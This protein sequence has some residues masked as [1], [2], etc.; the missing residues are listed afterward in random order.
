MGAFAVRGTV[1]H[2]GPPPLAQ[3]VCGV[4]PGWACRAIRR[5]QRLVSEPHGTLGLL[6]VAFSLFVLGVEVV[7]SPNL[8]RPRVLCDRVLR[9]LPAHVNCS[10][11]LQMPITSILAGCP[12]LSRCRLLAGVSR[13][14]R[15][16]L[17]RSSS[18]SFNWLWRSQCCPTGTRVCAS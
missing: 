9:E 13:S 17:L 11:C 15:T 2:R 16:L 14:T 4:V 10:R 18:S 8:P 1:T 3:N 5:V 7:D 12:C 6:L